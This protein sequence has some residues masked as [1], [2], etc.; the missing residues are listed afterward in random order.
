MAYYSPSQL[1]DGV[2]ITDALIGETNFNF[3]FT[4]SDPN[5]TPSAG[6]FTFETL[7]NNTGSYANITGLARGDKEVGGSSQIV[8]KPAATNSS[9]SGNTDDFIWSAN[10]VDGGT[11]ANNVLTWTPSVNV[12]V[13]TAK[14]RGTGGLAVNVV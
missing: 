2:L 7:P 3:E 1:A 14:L 6:Y 5:I 12:G 9:T 13:G 10:V 11:L 8:I 4:G